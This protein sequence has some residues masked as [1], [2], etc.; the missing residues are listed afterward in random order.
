M[1]WCAYV[2]L[3]RK[4]SF[5]VQL[6]KTESRTG[7]QSERQRRPGGMMNETLKLTAGL[8]R[9]KPTM[10]YGK[11]FIIVLPRVWRAFV[12]WYGLS[13]EF[14]RKV[15]IYPSQELSLRAAS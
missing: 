2:G 3:P 15:I 14:S 13:Q 11:D 8:P 4:D 12:K 1:R 7:G 6:E 5:G 9:I 10:T